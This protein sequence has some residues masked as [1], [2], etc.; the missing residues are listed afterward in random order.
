MIDQQFTSNL[1]PQAHAQETLSLAVLDP[2]GAGIAVNGSAGL[3]LRNVITLVIMVSAVLTLYHMMM[4][5][6]LWRRLA[7]GSWRQLSGF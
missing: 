2:N 1:I 6:L 5:A 3:L 7:I 4:G